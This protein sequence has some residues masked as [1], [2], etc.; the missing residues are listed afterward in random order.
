MEWMKISGTACAF[1]WM[2]A[3]GPAVCAEAMF[4]WN[5]GPAKESILNFVQDV[6]DGAGDRYV[7]P[8]RRIAVFDNDGT[9]WAEQP[10]YFQ[11]LFAIDR[12]K[13]LAPQ[14]P[15][16]QGQE[17]FA[18]LLRGDLSA[19]LAGGERSVAEVLAAT[20]A[21]MT[22]EEFEKIVSDWLGSAKHPQTGKPYNRMV[23]QPMLEL[24]EYL[25]ANGFKTFIVSGGGVEFMRV[26]AEQTYGIPPEQ[27]VGS[28]GRQKYE[29]SDEAGPLLIKLPEIDFVSD[30]PGKPVA[31]QR[32][33][34]RRPLAAF[35]NSDGDFQMLQW[36]CSGE[37]ARLCLII[38]HTD[39]AREW[40]YDRAS[41]IGHLDETLAAA[42]TKGWIVV[43]MKRDWKR[44]YS[45]DMID[46]S[47]A[48]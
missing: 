4:S 32:V 24:L 33:I 27:V 35:G 36:T 21:G 31:I 1:V 38:H 28:Y 40:A 39:A 41:R 26:F 6:T 46:E 34:G 44:I 2:L 13:A 5:E 25:R 47:T 11:A 3:A 10:V 23:Y 30:G 9:L 42:R 37:G 45:G 20:H 15:E 17:P 48:H 12:V 7:P 29:V 18:A 8:G 16:W 14:H 43:D 19:L 22:T